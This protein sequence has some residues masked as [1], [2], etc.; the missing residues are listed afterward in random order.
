[1]SLERDIMIMSLTGN[2]SRGAASAVRPK[3]ISCVLMSV[4]IIGNV[5]KASN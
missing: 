3:T 5:T 1:M 2:G 4:S